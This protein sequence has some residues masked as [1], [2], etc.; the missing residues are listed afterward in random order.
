[1]AGFKVD[2]FGR[3][4]QAALLVRKKNVICISQVGRDVG[5]NFACSL[6]IALGQSRRISQPRPTAKRAV[7]LSPPS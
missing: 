3:R 6:I 2:L 7:N 4:E 1:M 5:D